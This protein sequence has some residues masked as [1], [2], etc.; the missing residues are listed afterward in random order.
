MRH[1][2]ELGSSPCRR[3]RNFEQETARQEWSE[4][5]AAVTRIPPKVFTSFHQFVSCC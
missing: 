3:L 4:L 1:A 2:A 5:V